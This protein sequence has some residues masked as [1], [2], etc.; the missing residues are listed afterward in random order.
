MIRHTKGTL[1]WV[2]GETGNVRTLKGTGI[3]QIKGSYTENRFYLILK[4]DEDGVWYADNFGPVGWRGYVL[5]RI[6][7]R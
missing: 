7:E 1:R 5:Q 4:K 2:L 3:D 6:N